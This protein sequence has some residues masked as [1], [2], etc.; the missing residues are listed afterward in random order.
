MA[1][2]S[3]LDNWVAKYLC[4]PELAAPVGEGMVCHGARKYPTPAVT[5]IGLTIGGPVFVVL[6]IVTDDQSF[7]LAHI[8]SFTL[9]ARILQPTLEG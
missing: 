6:R 1:R 8:G 4:P 5:E 2:Q 7:V 3:I 9:T